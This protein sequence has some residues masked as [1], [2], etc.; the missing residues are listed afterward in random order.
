MVFFMVLFF[1]VCWLKP[2]KSI[3]EGRRKSLLILEEKKIISK[4]VRPKEE[5]Y[6]SLP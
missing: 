3:L 2:S 6:R 1:M 5:S 4:H